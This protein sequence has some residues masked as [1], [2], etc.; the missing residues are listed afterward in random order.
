MLSINDFLKYFSLFFLLISLIT[1]ILY[2][3]TENK[4]K[5]TDW[6]ALLVLIYLISHII[7]PWIVKE[8]IPDS[9]LINLL[10]SITIMLLGYIILHC[11]LIISSENPANRYLDF[12]HIGLLV[13][14]AIF[15]VNIFTVQVWG[16]EDLYFYILISI[17]V[18][19]AHITRKSK[20]NNLLFKIL[21][22]IVS[23]L[24]IV[25]VIVDPWLKNYE[26]PIDFGIIFES[27]TY[28]SKF[29][30]I[31]AFYFIG[32]LLQKGL[33]EEIEHKKVLHVVMLLIGGSYIYRNPISSD[34]VSKLPFF[35]DILIFVAGGTSYLLLPIL[36][37]IK[38]FKKS[39]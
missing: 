10:S 37:M 28:N 3:I 18:I 32:N 34:F 14:L 27:L 36:A 25:L 13:I 1:F 22:V 5:V 2:W 15:F 24:W 39:T 8:S 16:K 38:I 7:V 4:E 23:I 26:G 19:F 6:A 12:I 31:P 17:T 11:Q 35:K 33:I 29:L 9:N 20:K 21:S 30:W